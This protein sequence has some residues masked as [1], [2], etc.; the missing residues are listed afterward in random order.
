MK[1]RPHDEDD[2]ASTISPGSPVHISLRVA[3][4]LTAAIIGLVA[5]ATLGYA[6][7]EKRVSAVEI[8][9]ATGVTKSDLDL[10][11]ANVR[12][13]MLQSVWECSQQGP[14]VMRCWP[15]MVQQ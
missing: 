6:A 12:A 13:D 9:A 3:V 5:G 11:R 7:L 8:K 10:L 1:T 4:S 2:D 14:G 15:R